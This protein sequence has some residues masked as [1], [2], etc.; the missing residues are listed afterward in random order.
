[1]T[2]SYL[3]KTEALEDKEP[4]QRSMHGGVADRVWLW[5]LGVLRART[6]WDNEGYENARHEEVVNITVGLL[7]A[8]A[9]AYK[10]IA[11]E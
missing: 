11:S 8:A 9:P 4:V 5:A 10:M 1:V 7:F 3:G 6:E 2:Q